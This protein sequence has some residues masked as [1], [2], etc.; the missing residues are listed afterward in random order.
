MSHVSELQPVLLETNPDASKEEELIVPNNAS[1]G[2]SIN[3][4]QAPKSPEF[5][6]WG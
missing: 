3:I 6:P 4:P 1:H 2:F 5:V